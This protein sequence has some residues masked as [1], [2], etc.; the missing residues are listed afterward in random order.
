MR[1]AR[2][3]FDQRLDPHP[4]CSPWG[5][6]FPRDAPNLE[7][8]DDAANVALLLQL[9]EEPTVRASDDAFHMPKT[10]TRG[11][12]HV[13]LTLER[14]IRNNQQRNGL[15][16]LVITTIDESVVLRCDWTDEGS[17]GQAGALFRLAEA[18]SARCDRLTGVPNR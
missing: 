9:D 17:R 6:D 12:R 18:Y 10:Q 13:A 16:P 14:M 15:E 2:T 4:V 11:W 1:C 3:E 5:K 7:E 8:P